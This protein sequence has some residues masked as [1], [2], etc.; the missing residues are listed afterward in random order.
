MYKI[1]K[2]T[3]MAK[4]VLYR[5]LGMIVTV[6][7]TAQHSTLVTAYRTPSSSLDAVFSPP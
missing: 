7:V 3:K 5:G 2:Q 6:T 1:D 4:K